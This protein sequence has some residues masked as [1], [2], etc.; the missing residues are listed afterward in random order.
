MWLV[1]LALILIV[2]NFKLLEA[3]EH[4][5]QV[6]RNWPEETCTTKLAQLFRERG[7]TR[8]EVIGRTGI[9]DRTLTR[10]TTIPSYPITNRYRAV[11]SDLL[12]VDPEELDT[13]IT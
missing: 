6:G 13:P 9:G 12:Q 4:M 11:L 1:A 10:L 5:A 2:I 7:L 8:V 3:G